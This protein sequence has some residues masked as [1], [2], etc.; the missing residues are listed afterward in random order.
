MKKFNGRSVAKGASLSKVPFATLSGRFQFDSDDDNRTILCGNSSYG[1]NY[2]LWNTELFNTV[3][4]GTV[5][6][7]T[8][9]ISNTYGGVSF[10]MPSASKVRWDWQHRPINSNGYSKNYRAQIWTTASFGSGIGGTNWTLRADQT[11]TSNTTTGGWL[12]N[13]VT[14]TSEI[15]EGHYVMFVVGLDNHSI[16]ATTYLSFQST[17]SLTS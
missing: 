11:F 2:Y 8:Q 12:T 6:T 4:S 13:N 10:R 3:G 16:T 14:T 7:T 1:T 15:P 17:A 9:S 5:D